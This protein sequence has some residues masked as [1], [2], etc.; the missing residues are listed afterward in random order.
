M[1][2]P[3]LY[4]PT[5]AAQRCSLTGS[6]WS[7]TIVPRPTSLSLTNILG[8]TLSHVLLADSKLAPR[9]LARFRN[10][11][12]YRFIPGGV[13]TYTDLTTEPIY[14]AVAHRLGEWHAVL[15]VV[16]TE[17]SRTCMDGNQEQSTSKP[18]TPDKPTPN[19]WTVIH[20]WVLALPASTSADHKRNTMLLR[21]LE[22]SVAE[23]VDTPGLGYN[24]VSS[25]PQTLDIKAA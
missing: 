10:G 11:M 21:E 15:P 22:R 13:C 25:F 23:L 12:M 4:E 14:K 1:P 8:E 5:A 2:K 24:G 6:V 16:S 20:K 7:S 18:L 9:L 3:F 17:D 19:I